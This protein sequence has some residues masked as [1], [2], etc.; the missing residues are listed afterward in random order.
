MIIFI[1]PTYAAVLA[2]L[3]FGLGFRTIRMRQALQ[4]SIGDADNKKMLRAMR[5]VAN[6]TEYVPFTLL[7]IFM[8]ELQG[9]HSIAVHG[10]CV[11][12]TLGRLFHAYGVSQVKEDLRFR[13]VGMVMTFTAMLG[14]A[15]YLV[16]VGTWRA[17]TA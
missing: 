12:L 5:V 16:F 7:L 2:F 8:L 6:F 14:T 9:G 3:L 1:T 17:V 15:S 11:C 13:T 4:I 10:L